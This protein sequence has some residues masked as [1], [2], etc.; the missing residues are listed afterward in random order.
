VS[1]KSS[2]HDPFTDPKTS[3]R[4]PLVLGFVAQLHTIIKVIGVFSITNKSPMK[5]F[6]LIV[7]FQTKKA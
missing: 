3:S 4:L 2:E 1:N 7:T 5:T 6:S